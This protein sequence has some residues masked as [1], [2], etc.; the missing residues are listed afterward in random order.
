[1]LLR[2]P[3]RLIAKHL[4]VSLRFLL[5]HDKSKDSLY[6]KG[7]GGDTP[8]LLHIRQRRQ[9]LREQSRHDDDIIQ[10]LLRHDRTKQSLLIPSKA[11]Q[12]SPLYYVASQEIPFLSE[13]VE[14]ED[15]EV[16]LDE[17]LEFL[18]IQT[19]EALEIHHGRLEP[20]DP[21]KEK[22]EL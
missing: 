3:L 22:G 21:W 14:E 12:R 19:Y 16:I 1:M 9:I 5:E 17:R 6:Y 8:I 10:L 13:D 20:S 15:C 11:K 7:R 18:L 2:C 4:P